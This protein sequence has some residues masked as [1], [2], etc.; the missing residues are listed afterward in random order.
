MFR[1]V[2]R[3]MV[4][5]T[6]IAL[7]AGCGGYTDQ[8]DP[9]ITSEDRVSACGGFESQ[10]SPLLGDPVDYCAAEVLHWLYEADTQILK[11]ADARVLLN[12]CGDHAMTVAEQDGV[13]VFTETDDPEFG[14]ARCACMCVFD[15]AIE[16]TG[17]TTGVIPIRIQREVSDWPEGSGLILEAELDLSLGSGFITIDETDVYPWCGEE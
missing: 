6:A 7:V 2:T 9:V 8:N 5:I 12:C 1:Q 14:D 16:V 10:G 4:V 11:L 15:F 13:Y 17:I 3:M